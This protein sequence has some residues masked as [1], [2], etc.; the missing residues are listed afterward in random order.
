MIWGGCP[1]IRKSEPEEDDSLWKSDQ[2][3]SNTSGK[4]SFYNT[5]IAGAKMVNKASIIF[6]QNEE[7]IQTS[8]SDGEFPISS[9]VELIFYNSAK[10][11]FPI[12]EML[13]TSQARPP[14]NANQVPVTSAGVMYPSL[15]SQ[16]STAD[17]SVVDFP[18]SRGHRPGLQI[19]E[20]PSLSKEDSG[21]QTAQIVS[22]I[23]EL[24]P[25]VVF[26]EYR[27]E[28]RY[29][30]IKARSLSLD[31]LRT[32]QWI[33]VPPRSASLEWRSSSK[34]N[35][36]PIQKVTVSS[37]PLEVN[38]Q[39]YDLATIDYKFHNSLYSSGSEDS[40]QEDN[41][42]VWATFIPLTPKGGCETSMSKT[43]GTSIRTS[44]LEFLEN[45]INNRKEELQTKEK[46]NFAISSE[47]SGKQ[48]DSIN[49]AY[50]AIIKRVIV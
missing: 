46:S 42:S 27:K 13:E 18:V 24:T 45:I 41:E 20:E 19:L 8:E 47:V 38:S 34:S 22:E 2:N 32:E 44:Q 6:A 48:A 12:S 16:R 37:I 31:N 5:Q 39:I 4:N 50:D 29:P 26:R 49:R 43:Q 25:S 14:I 9:E 1:C 17:E 10:K 3:P 36:L 11:T 30:R 40:S 15:T 21:A 33:T 7:N 35:L 23:S 28:K